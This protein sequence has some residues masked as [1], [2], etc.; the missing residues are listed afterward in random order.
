MKKRG[1]KLLS[2][3]RSKVP[4]G[5]T[6]FYA[7]YLIDEKPKTGKEIMDEAGKRSEGEW[8]PSPGLIYP[9]LGRLIKDELIEENQYGKFQITNKG[10]EKLEQHEQLQEQLDK[11]LKLVMKLGLSMFKKGKMLV[12]ESMD[13][14]LSVTSRIKEQVGKGSIEFQ[15]KFYSN[16]KNFLESELQKIE[17]LDLQKIDE[18]NNVN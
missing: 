12:E 9:L 2:R 7:L 16:Y 5:F 15:R 18:K 11:Q 6:R 10:K 8:R 14:I 1:M 17:K 4:R 3:V 13:R